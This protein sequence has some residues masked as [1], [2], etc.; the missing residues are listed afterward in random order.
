M[1]KKEI[2]VWYSWQDNEVY[3]IDLNMYPLRASPFEIKSDG[4]S[5][6]TN[7]LS[8]V[9]LCYLKYRFSEIWTDVFRNVKTIINH[10]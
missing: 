4:L 5:K 8:P 6:F 7:A 2:Y 1:G 3:D 9:L 10:L